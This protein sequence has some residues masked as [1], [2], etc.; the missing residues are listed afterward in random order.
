MKAIADEAVA[1][2]PTV[3]RWSCGRGWGQTPAMRRAAT[4]AGTSSSAGQSA[5]LAAPA[6]DPETPM[7]VIYT[8]GTT[9]QPKGAVHVHGGFLVKIAEECA[10]QLDVGDGRPVHVGDRHGLDH[11]P[12]RGGRRPARSARRW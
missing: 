5:E 12:A 10:F 3:R 4:T 9:G 2:A 7:M 1:A 8:S 6:L 11:G